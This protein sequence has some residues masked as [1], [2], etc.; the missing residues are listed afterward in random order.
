MAVRVAHDV[1]MR[2]VE[3]IRS[4][5][6]EPRHEVDRVFLRRKKAVQTGWRCASA[7][8]LRHTAGAHLRVPAERL[9]IA[10]E[11]GV[12]LDPVDGVRPGRRVGVVTYRDRVSN[13]YAG[14]DGDR[15][16]DQHDDGLARIKSSMY[17]READAGFMRSSPGTEDAR[18]PLQAKD[19]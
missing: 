17:V 12:E 14:H 3:T 19:T 18:Q 8:R 15:D 4:S 13:L 11:C 16:D 1:I 10:A 9:S 2:R 5:M 7:V 6:F